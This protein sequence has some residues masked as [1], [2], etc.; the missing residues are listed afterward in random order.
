M[1]PSVGKKGF[2]AKGRIPPNTA[3]LKKAFGRATPLRGSAL[4]QTAGTSLTS[5]DVDERSERKDGRRPR[6]TS[7]DLVSSEFP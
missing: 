6:A 5:D 3:L 7:V 1:G 4:P 2:E